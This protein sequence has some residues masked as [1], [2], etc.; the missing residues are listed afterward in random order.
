MT[1]GITELPP[2]GMQLGGVALAG[3][4]ERGTKTTEGL[5]LLFTTARDHGPG[6]PAPDRAAV[7]VV[8]P[9]HR[10]L[11]REDL[12]PRRAECSGHGADLGRPVDP[13]PAA[14]GRRHPR[15]G[16]LSRPGASGL[17]GPVQGVR[18]GH[19]RRPPPPRRRVPP[20][21]AAAHPVQRSDHVGRPPPGRAAG[22]RRRARRTRRSLAHGPFRGRRTPG[23]R[24]SAAASANGATRGPI[25]SRRLGL[26]FRFADGS[27]SARGV[28]LARPPPAGPGSAACSAG[29]V[30]AL[31]H[32]PGRTPVRCH[33]RHHLR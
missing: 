24:R 15:T 30:R 23:R 19:T 25:G 33:R 12:P 17:A 22:R 18:D 26:G 29:P 31:I 2:E 6:P 14:H 10:Q 4:A 20:A 11:P 1:V 3:D 9:G 7:G 5:S 16:R 13:V 28:G 27:G 32:A 8:G 21:P